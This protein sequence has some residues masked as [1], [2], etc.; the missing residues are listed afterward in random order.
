[1]DGINASRDRLERAKQNTLVETNA[2]AIAETLRQLRAAPE[3]HRRRWIWE[4][5][6]NAADA[7]DAEKKTNK[8]QID[9]TGEAVVFKHDGAAFDEEELSHLIYHGSTK[10]A[11]PTKR[12][13]F[14]SGFITIHLVSEV[15]EI[16]GVLKQ[17]ED[18]YFSFRFNLNRSGTAAPE[19]QAAMEAA[20]AECLTSMGPSRQTDSFSTTFTC[21]LGDHARAAVTAGI[22]ELERAA[23]YV[24][25]LVEE[26]SEIALSSERGT[27]RWQKAR[28]ERS[29]EVSYVDIS[30]EAAGS[31]S[32][33]RLAIVGDHASAAALVVLLEQHGSA[34][35]VTADPNLPRLFYPLPLVGTEALQLPF[36]V[37]SAKFEPTEPRNGILAGANV[38]ESVPT[39]ANWQLLSALPNLYVTLVEEAARKGW[40]NPYVLAALKPVPAKDWLD[41]RRFNESLLRRLVEYLRAEGGPRLID[42]I[43]GPRA[44]FAQMLLPVGERAISVHALAAELK[45]LKPRLPVATLVGP[46]NDLL[47]GWADLLGQDREQLR[48]ALTTE[49]L[50]R[51][52]RTRCSDME[53]LKALLE[54]GSAG[55]RSLP[56]LNDLMEQIPEQR[57]EPL[58]KSCAILPDQHGKLRSIGDLRLDG[59]IDDEL[60]TICAE[61]GDDV[62]GELLDNRIS[63]RA[64]SLFQAAKGRVLTNDECLERALK[65]V[66]EHAREKKSAYHAANARLLRWLI[67]HGR[68]ERIDGYPVW[69]AEGNTVLRKGSAMLLPSLLWDEAARPFTDVFDVGRRLHDAYRD[70]LDEPHWT[71]LEGLNV[72][73]RGLFTSDSI[74]T[75]ESMHAEDTLSEE[76]EHKSTVATGLAQIIFLKG[77]EGV[78]ADLRKSKAKARRFLE[79]LLRYVIKAERSWVNGIATKCSC[80]ATHTLR[81]GWLALVRNNGWVPAGKGRGERP[82]AA[83]V[84]SLLDEELKQHILSDADSARFLLK[85]D[86]GLADLLRVGVPE[87][88]RFQLDQL[89]AK[90]Y[91]SEE[92][93][94]E[95]VEIVL[96]DR[97]IRDLVLEKKREKEI[98]ERNQNVGKLI[99]DLLRKELEAES[100]TVRRRPVGSDFE[101][102]SDFVDGGQEQLL[103]VGRYILEVK[104]TSTAFVRMTLRQGIESCKAEHAHRYALCVVPLTQTP[105]D[106]AAVRANARFVV[107]IGA[108]LKEKVKAA[109]E[110]KTLEQT[111]SPSSAGAVAIDLVQSQVKLRISSSV[112]EGTRTFEQFVELLK[113]RKA[114]ERSLDLTKAAPLT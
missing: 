97:S 30:R 95:S 19:I 89:S 98:V 58:L 2:Q 65:K 44:G 103:D 28:W 61:L 39:A 52:V 64:K 69:A 100:V 101:V 9:V 57:L 112:W 22:G 109:G 49:S 4:L 36:A 68:A 88:K 27:V 25:A 7:R 51:E 56:W 37:A 106:E 92:A 114:E 67:G 11:D 86:I 62:R 31:T 78:L 46:L 55:E 108:H 42:T 104:A 54:S 105:M 66:G 50:A 90:I 80:G 18:T 41:E 110:L 21:G 70:V 71:T 74:E 73:K 23:P 13:K 83:N 59:G 26:L 34:V 45:P 76:S 113:A 48:E 81:P 10:Q 24:L 8:I 82:A 1:M 72:L 12:G 29:G 38:E 33:H 15:V 63:G 75:V 6:Q 40:S 87:S 16:G 60:K 20:W 5:I 14:G 17:S 111:I 85:L 107:G 94:I 79:F 102:E 99:E 43:E 3:I 53:G 96:T 35:G 32:M 47:V 91:D 77:D 93:T 84:A